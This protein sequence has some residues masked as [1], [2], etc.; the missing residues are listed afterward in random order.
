MMQI[1]VM[2]ELVHEQS[3]FE[4]LAHIGEVVIAGEQRKK[5]V[6]RDDQVVSG[7]LG[8]AIQI[9]ALVAVAEDGIVPRLASLRLEVLMSER[10][11]RVTERLARDVAQVQRLL[12]NCRVLRIDMQDES[13]TLEGTHDKIDRRLVRL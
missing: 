11:E 7:Q 3:S 13:L 1:K 5:V 9:R 10:R 4:H 2:T 12:G 6:E 8:Q